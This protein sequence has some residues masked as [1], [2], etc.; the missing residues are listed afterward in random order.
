MSTKDTCK[1]IK[2]SFLFLQVRKLG[3]RE[4]KHIALSCPVL[5]TEL[6]VEF[7]TLFFPLL[8]LLH[9][10]FQCED[11]LHVLKL[12]YPHAFWTGPALSKN[13]ETLSTAT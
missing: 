12:I 2:S 10:G 3:P 6:G 8:I 7:Q 5:E 11:D 9:P 13:S 4:F 1:E